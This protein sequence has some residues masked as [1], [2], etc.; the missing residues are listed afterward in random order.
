MV[1]VFVIGGSTYEE[2]RNIRLLNENRTDSPIPGLTVS[3]GSTSVQSCKTFL[4]DLADAKAC[5]MYNNTRR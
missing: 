3:L 4:Q 1:V 2:A 5:G